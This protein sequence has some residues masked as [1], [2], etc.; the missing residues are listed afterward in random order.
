MVR[1]RYSAVVKLVALFLFAVFI[2]PSLFKLF[3]APSGPLDGED[4]SELGVKT[5][6][7]HGGAVK[8]GYDSNDWTEKPELA[9]VFDS[10]TM[11]NYEPTNLSP[12]EG[13]G[14]GGVP[15]RLAPTEKAS[16]DRTV[17]EFGF[18]MVASDK[19]SLDRRIKDT[20]P[21]E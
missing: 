7:R 11:G 1:L 3:S 18:N 5:N 10:S 16:G 21:G 6:D 4:I 9:A 19:I 13:P 20:R 8:S 17:A 14:E 12:R 15:V 2:L